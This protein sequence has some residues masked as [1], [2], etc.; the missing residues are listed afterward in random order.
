M[1]KAGRI[2]GYIVFL[3]VVVIGLLEILAR[4]IDGWNQWLNI[5]GNP[6]HRMPPHSAPDI[7]SDGIR[8]KREASDFHEEDFNIIFLGDSFTYGLWLNDVDAIPQVFEKI[9]REHYP[10]RKI[11]VAN[12]GWVSASPLLEF[13]LLKDIGKKYHPDLIIQVIDMTDVGDDLYYDDI[14]NHRH[15]YAIGRYLPT[16]TL[17]LQKSIQKHT[18]WDNLFRAVFGVP[19][20]RYF[21]VEQPLEQT[22]YGF[23]FL[24]SHVDQTYEYAKDELSARYLMVVIPRYFQYRPEESPDDWEAKDGEYSTPG[25]YSLEPFKYFDEMKAKV[26]YPVYSLLPDFRDSKITPTV[27]HNDAHPNK[28]GAHLAAEAIFRDCEQV[29]CFSGMK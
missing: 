25:P 23:D 26:P 17:L 27:F 4:Q 2:V 10:N 1:N 19:R 21:I 12:F 24:K 9:A 8:S 3:L 22:R 16:T 14:I 13:R 20:K 15:I 28:D 5:I 18:H 7:N 11:N 29:K 6:D